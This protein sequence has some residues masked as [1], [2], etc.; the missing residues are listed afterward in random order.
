MN[1]VQCSGE[2]RHYFDAEVYAVC[3]VC[4]AK[5]MTEELAAAQEAVQERENGKIAKKQK[6]KKIFWGK[7]KESTEEEKGT[8]VKTEVQPSKTSDGNSTVRSISGSRAQSAWKEGEGKY[9]I[10]E[11]L[12]QPSGL[13][14]QQSS[15]EQSSHEEWGRAIPFVSA[16]HPDNDTKKEQEEPIIHEKVDID[17]IKTI[18]IFGDRNESEPVTG[19]L[20]CVK[21]EYRGESFPL[22][23]GVNVIARGGAADVCLKKDTKVSRQKH[24]S[25]I[26]EPKKKVFYIGEGE[27]SLTYCNEELVYGKQ[28]LKAY[29]SIEIGNGLYLFIPFSGERF[30]WDREI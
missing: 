16:P 13:S 17:D 25:V 22:K 5:T 26:Y 28:E 8:E 15:G 20:V 3:P 6:K 4:G 9:P 27:S 7:E 29:D 10:T 19:W 1:K 12:V 11:I 18:T 21:G 23:A 30:D 2:G 14:K 24:A